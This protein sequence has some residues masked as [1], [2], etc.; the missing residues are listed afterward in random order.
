MH[1]FPFHRK[2]PKTVPTVELR[3]F[4]LNKCP[5]KIRKILHTHPKSGSAISCNT[6]F[7]NVEDFDDALNAWIR[8]SSDIPSQIKAL[9]EKL[10]FFEAEILSN[11]LHWRAKE[12]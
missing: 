6:Q 2:P 8:R 7:D 9:H 4:N 10:D 5:C 12:V 11:F 3:G 1:M